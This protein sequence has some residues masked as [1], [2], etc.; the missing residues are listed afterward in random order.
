VLPCCV[1]ELSQ[2][3]AWTCWSSRSSVSA[4]PT[5]DVYIRV[6]IFKV[7]SLESTWHIKGRSRSTTGG[8]SPPPLMC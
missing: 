6:N 5:T 4:T 3:E 7:S 2:H 1:S 8:V